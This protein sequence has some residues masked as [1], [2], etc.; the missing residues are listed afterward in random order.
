M[1]MIQHLSVDTLV[2]VCLWLLT[3]AGIGVAF[4]SVTVDQTWVLRFH[5]TIN[6][7]YQQQGS[8]LEKLIPPEMVHRDVHAAIDHHERMGNV[9][10]NDVVAPFGPTKALN[11]EH[12]KR[13]CTLISS[14]ATVLVSDEHSLRAMVNPQNGYTKTIVFAC[15]R[16]ADKHIIDALTGL[17][18]TMAIT[19]GSGVPTY[20][21]QALPTSRVLGSGIATT[22]TNVIN[23]TELLDK[24]S[25][26]PGSDGR[27]MLYGPGQ[28][29]DV[30]AITQASSSDFTRNRIHDRGSINGIEWEGF[31]WQMIAD[32]VDP[33]ISVLQRMLALSGTTRTMI[34]FHKGAVGLSI[35][36][37]LGDPQINQRP[38]LQSNP[39]QIRQPMMQA[40]TRVWE[41][42]VVR[43]DVLEN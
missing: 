41:G 2:Q 29:R 7:V 34:A 15:G 19:S 38:D 11:P 24:A 6:I 13:A 42:G 4:G 21:T 14:D 39:I 26:P 10:A 33:S 28:T 20:G 37:S 18:Q 35:G 43:L 16:R 22:L 23:C 1:D 17:S 31:F 9:I 36:R 3:A 5:D 25:V 8:V 27:V 30:M 32:V 40:A 12:S